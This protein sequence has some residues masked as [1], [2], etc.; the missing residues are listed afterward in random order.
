MRFQTIETL[1]FENA[2]FM[3]TG[4]NFSLKATDVIIIVS[5]VWVVGKTKKV[6]V[7]KRKHNSVDK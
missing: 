5:L 2:L 4:E 7:F 6:R 3:P 1:S